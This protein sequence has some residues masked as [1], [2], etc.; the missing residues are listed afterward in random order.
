MIDEKTVR[1]DIRPVVEQLISATVAEDPRTLH[2]RLH[3]HG[4][5]ARALCS[6]AQVS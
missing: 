3:P 1:D 2:Q 6:V 4:Q 5:A